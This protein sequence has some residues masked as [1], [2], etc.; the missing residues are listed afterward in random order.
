MPDQEVPS[1]P[2]L[3]PGTRVEVRQRFDRSW[4]RGFEVAGVE[5]SGY[6]VLR[7]SDRT[8]L[9]TTFGSDEVRMERRRHGLWW[10]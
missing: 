8:V 10:V 9:P 5:D 6:Q 7:L 3:Q 1:S 2:T 4:A